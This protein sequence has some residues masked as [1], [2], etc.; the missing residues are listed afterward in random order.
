LTFSVLRATEYTVVDDDEGSVEY[1]SETALPESGPL[2]ILYVVHGFPPDT[3]A[4]TEV[5][6]LG[7]AREME[8]LGHRCAV[9]TRAPADRSEA[10]GG[11][12]DFSLARGDFEGLEVWRM[13]R[14]IGKQ[15]LRD[16]YRHPAAEEVFRQVVADVRPDVVHFQH[17]L[18]LSAELPR[19]AGEMGISTVI[20]CNDYWALCA[21]VQLI[22]PDGERCEGNQGLACQPCVKD[23]GAKRIEL[24]RRYEALIRPVFK[25]LRVVDRLLPGGAP[26]TAERPVGFR[27]KLGRWMEGFSDLEQ[28]QPTT[29]GGYGSA[30][31]LIAPSRFLRDLHLETGSF[32]EA[33]F[34]F[35]D[36]GTSCEHLERGSKFPDPEGRVRFGFIGSL[37]WYKGP[38]VLL[39]AMKLLAGQ[40][41]KL[42]IFGD[43]R[44]EED[45][46][47]RQLQDLAAGAAVDFRG[48]FD[49]ARLD[50]VHREIDVLIVPSIWFE[51]SPITIHE[52]FLLGSPPVVSDIGGM[53]ELVTDGRDGMHFEVGNPRDLADVLG[54][55]IADPG[56]APR[57]AKAAP[58]IKTLPE[59][60]REMEYR[61]RSLCCR[62]GE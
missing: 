7:L 28:R 48:R 32:D 17:L 5:H 38:E 21:R 20:T 8:K 51:N 31:L 58:R 29:L 46:Y 33:R 56:L 12:A 24:F 25:A 16:S 43:F 61:Y 39:E 22:R 37:V 40:P 18:H 42:E 49:N 10:D 4:G 19:I 55:F 59:N 26:A 15:R 41:A 35:S 9:L 6:T 57:L 36:Y 1:S 54:R 45:D 3:W 60:A 53:A 2:R 47:H 52:A 62:R 27:Q 13:T 50:E 44:P 30:D 34:V 11:A 14:R 23:Q